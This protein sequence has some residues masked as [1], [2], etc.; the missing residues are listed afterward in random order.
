MPAAPGHRRHHRPRP[1]DGALVGPARGPR[2]SR[3]Q[4]AAAGRGLRP[5]ARHHPAHLAH[6]H[7]PPPPEH[8]STSLHQALRQPPRPPP[9]G[10]ERH[11]APDPHRRTTPRQH[12]PLTTHRGPGG[13]SA[14]REPPTHPPTATHHPNDAEK[15]AGQTRTRTRSCTSAGQRPDVVPDGALASRSQPLPDVPGRHQANARSNTHTKKNPVSGMSRARPRLSCAPVAPT[16]HTGEAGI[17]PRHR[18]RRGARDNPATDRAQ[19]AGCGTRTPLS[20]PGYAES[21]SVVLAAPTA[22]GSPAGA[23]RHPAWGGRTH[24]AAT[25]DRYPASAPRL[26]MPG[27][28]QPLHPDAASTV[29][30]RTIRCAERRIG[31]QYASGGRAVRPRPR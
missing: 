18:A 4:E 14:L 3:Q 24:C 15:A 9:R 27:A 26:A 20:D 11:R 7:T 10:H 17:A 22:P 23:V 31:D 8:K 6:R 19:R 29:W 13:K 5:P 16:P 25:A 2:G 12:P 1:A 21:V 30:P 28:P